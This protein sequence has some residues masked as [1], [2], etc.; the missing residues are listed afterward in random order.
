MKIHWKSLI[1]SI[2]A[3]L[4]TGALSGFLVRDDFARYQELNQPP[5]SPPMLLFPII[6]TLLYILMGIS[7]WLVWE[8]S[9]LFTTPGGNTYVLQLIVNFFWPILFFREGWYL[10][11]FIWLLLL[12]ALVI[13]MIFQ[14]YQ[15]SP[16]ASFLQFPYVLWLVFAG[17][18][19]L[20]IWILN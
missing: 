4:A 19:N 2:A 17:Y 14:F 1:V 5:L 12:L 6:W 18:L 9:A 10:F 15:I 3:S 11:S 20:G 7:A 16:P 8:K 13:L